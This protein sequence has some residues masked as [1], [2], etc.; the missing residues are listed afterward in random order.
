MGS[1]LCHQQH[2][3]NIMRKISQQRH[4]EISQK[5]RDGQSHRQIARECG[6]S[7]VTITNPRKTLPDELP[8][9]K[10]GR[11][12]KLLLHHQRFLDR[13]FKGCS[14]KNV[15]QAC[16]TIKERFNTIRSRTT[17]RKTLIKLQFKASVMVKKPLMS[18]RHK[19][20]TSKTALPSP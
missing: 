13:Q 12:K 20:N 10:I 2:H 14:I 1:S 15:R 19:R 9:P 7:V 5:L 17:T 16:N 4:R 18:K 3:I 11:P 8:K 6:T